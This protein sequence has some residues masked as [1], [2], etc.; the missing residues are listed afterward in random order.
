M[1]RVDWFV[2]FKMFIKE[3]ETSVASMQL[4]SQVLSLSETLEARRDVLNT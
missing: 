3:R 1:L 4:I 2:W